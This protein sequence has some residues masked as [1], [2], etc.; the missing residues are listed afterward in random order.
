MDSSAVSYIAADLLKPQGTV[1]T[2]FSHVPLFVK[3]IQSDK[4]QHRR[5]LD[6]TPLI[7][8]VANAS[9]NINPILLSSEKQ[10]IVQGMVEAMNVCNAPSHGSANLY[11]VYDIYKTTSQEKFGTLL[12][13]EGGNGSISF[14]GTDYLLPFNLASLILHPYQF[15]RTQIA[16]RIGKKYFNKYLNKRRDVVD[17]LEKYVSNIFLNQSVLDAYN[18]KEDIAKNDKE[19]Y[20]HISDV[21]EIKELFIDFYY[22]RSL[23]GAVCGHYYGFE[24]RDPCTD[25]DLME[26]FFSIPNEAF[27]DDHY[28]NRMLV[29]RMMSGKIPDK[30]LFEKEKVCKVLTYHIE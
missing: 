20:R 27:F 21:Q 12:S 23:R 19:I 16:K 15:L 9:G 4:E 29:K 14:A 13:G 26:Y 8:E 17:S 1:L 10:S 24:L 6:E 7:T 2:T 30:V 28:N 11:W 25:L 18:I 5:I 3:E 22:L